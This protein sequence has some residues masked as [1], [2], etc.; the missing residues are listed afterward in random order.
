M[1]IKVLNRTK[2]PRP[3][4]KIPSTQLIDSIKKVA[5]FIK[6]FRLGLFLCL[7]LSHN[8]MGVVRL[9]GLPKGQITSIQNS[10][11]GKVFSV[12]SNLFSLF[13]L[14]R[15]Y[16]ILVFGLLLSSIGSG[17]T[18][19]AVFGALSKMGASSVEFSL[20]YALTILPGLFA[21]GLSE[22]LSR[23]FNWGVLLIGAQIL[24]AASLMLPIYG[25]QV[26]SK[27]MILSAEFIGSALAGFIFP[28]SQSI[29]KR[30]F[31]SNEMGLMVKLDSALFSVNVVLGVGLGSLLYD[32][33]GSL[34]YLTLDFVSYLLAGMFILISCV[35]CFHRMSPEK[36]TPEMV[37]KPSFSLSTL[38]PQKRLAFFMLPMLSLIA[39]PA[40]ALLPVLA[41]RFGS[42]VGMFDLAFTPAVIF[43]LARSLGQMIGPWL[44]PTRALGRLGEKGGVFWAGSLL[45][46]ALYALAGVMENPWVCGL[47]VVCAHVSSNVVFVV[48]SYSLQS[49]FHSLEI[50]GA[51]ARVYQLQLLVMTTMSL[52]AGFSA[53]SM[54]A[55]WALFL[56]L[57][58][59]ALF[60]FVMREK[61][62]VK[63]TFGGADR[64]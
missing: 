41:S 13:Q 39:T 17:L 61:R 10:T 51:S 21:S 1:I 12:K 54:G 38:E 15:R 24:G 37:G 30:T 14:H 56:E 7:Q 8:E 47:L 3:E 60:Y 27:W 16:F 29:L 22:R 44:V 46:V 53:N 25:L 4:K 6:N 20:A 50:A 58:P 55:L 63:T 45:F 2:N 40:M 9:A 35:G 42:S 11:P 52:L 28:I 48:G 64:I 31:S 49:A 23:R 36:S 34:S 19:V 32:R 43:L 33:V 18:Q 26:Q 62:G 5:F 59:A 57:V